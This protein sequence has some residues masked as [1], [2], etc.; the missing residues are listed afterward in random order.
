MVAGAGEIWRKPLPYKDLEKI[1]EKSWQS[2]YI[3][4]TGYTQGERYEALYLD[5]LEA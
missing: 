2:R 3:E 1:K 4:Y 5:G